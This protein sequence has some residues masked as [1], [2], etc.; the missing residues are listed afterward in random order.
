MKLEYSYEEIR[1][2]KWV[3]LRTFQFDRKYKISSLG[4]IMSY[5]GTVQKL[6]TPQKDNYGELI[7]MLTSRDRE[8]CHNIRIGKTVA[9]HFVPNPNN[10]KFIR[11]KDG[12]KLNCRADNIEWCELT[13]KMQ[14]QYAG[15]QKRVNQYTLDRTYLRTFNSIQEAKEKT[16]ANSIGSACKADGKSSGGYIWRYEEEYPAGENIVVEQKV[17]QKINQYDKDGNLIHTWQSI[18]EIKEKCPEIKQ[19]SNITHC[20]KGRRNSA[21]GYKWKYSE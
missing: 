5:Y 4:R 20:C 7:V 8:T 11:H 2:E 12:N 16:G 6:M 1:T 18:S 3:D 19:I 9:Q 17:I 15:F 13:S 10:Y 14:N 21:Y